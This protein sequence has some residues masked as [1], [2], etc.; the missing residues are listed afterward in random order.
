MVNAVGLVN[1][2][3]RTFDTSSTF[4]QNMDYFI[5]FMR[6][7]SQPTPGVS[8]SLW[9]SLLFLAVLISSPIIQAISLGCSFIHCKQF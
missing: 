1:D 7:A 5:L 8:F 4:K 9:G 2:Q 6:S 3:N